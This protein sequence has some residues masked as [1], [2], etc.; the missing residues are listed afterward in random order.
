MVTISN[1]A[2]PEAKDFTVGH[3]ATRVSPDIKREI[4]SAIANIE[5]GSVEVII[6]DGKVVQIERRE[7]IRISRNGCGR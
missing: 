6:H 5:Y 4:L 3:P 2:D 1:M 7:K